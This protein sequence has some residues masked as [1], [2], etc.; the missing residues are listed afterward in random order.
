M[1][2]ESVL[3]HGC[4]A[5]TRADH[6]TPLFLRRMFSV[7]KI[8]LSEIFRLRRSTPGKRGPSTQEKARLCLAV[9][10]LLPLTFENSMSLHY[11]RCCVHD[12]MSCSFFLHLS[13][14]GAFEHVTV[15]IPSVLYGNKLALRTS[16]VSS[17]LEARP[18]LWPR[19]I[20][21]LFLNRTKES[22]FQTSSF[23]RGFWNALCF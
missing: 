21:L 22:T 15:E 1:C 9:N 4:E 19:C 12:D 20:T 17:E 18:G 13:L 11:F 8:M 5:K 14:E 16:S 23:Q 6:S 10:S 2:V 3:R 7:M